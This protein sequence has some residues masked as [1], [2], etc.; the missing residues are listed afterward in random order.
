MANYNTPWNKG[1]TGIYSQ[2]TL[3]KMSDTAKE[4]TGE[5]NPM[6]GRHHTEKSKLKMSE[7]LKGH[8]VSEETRRKMSIATKNENNPFY[9]RHHTKEAIEKIRLA[10]EGLHLGENHP[11]Y[12]KHHSEEAILKMSKSHKGQKRSEESKRKQSESRKGMK[13]SEEHNQKISE[14][15]KGENNSMY[16]RL[17][18]NA[19]SWR[20]GL[21][22]EPY[23]P[24]FNRQL[25]ELIRQRDGYKCQL[26][27]M[28]EIENIKKLTVHH[29]DYVKKNCLPSNL[30]ALCRSCNSK[31]N[32]DRDYWEEY[33]KDKILEKVR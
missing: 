21:S 7:A 25:K 24:E 32:A 8:L 2:E 4:R 1:K 22:F 3:K 15:Q 12:G 18:E 19:P 11:M 27:G 16:N 9:G 6:W 14:A 5:D 10:N 28:P 33:F 31:V 17:G 23:T 30:T 20:G 26:C 13:F 29:I